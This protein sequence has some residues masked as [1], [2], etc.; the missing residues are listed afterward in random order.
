MKESVRIAA[1]AIKGLND[2]TFKG[3]IVV[4]GST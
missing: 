3:E 1:N 4:F 2:I